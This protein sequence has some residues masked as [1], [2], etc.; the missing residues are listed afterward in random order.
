MT[1]DF[2]SAIPIHARQVWQKRLLYTQQKLKDNLTA[3]NLLEIRNLGSTVDID[4]VTK[5]EGSGGNANIQAKITARGAVPDV[6]DVKISE[7]DYKQYQIALGFYVNERELA[8]APELKAQKVDWCTRNIH[9]LEDYMFFNGDSTINLTGLQTAAEA[10][11]NGKGVASSA[12]GS[13][14]N[15]VGAWDGT[16]TDIDIQRDVVEMMSRIGDE[17][18]NSPMYLV[19]RRANLKGIRTLDDMR[20]SYADELLDLFGANSVNDFLRYSSYCPSG[21]VYLVA[22]DGAAAE[23]TISQDLMVD[24]SYPKEKGANYYVELRE[25][26]N[27]FQRYDD[28]A[29]VEI[30]VT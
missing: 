15:N 16:D 3:R 9:R 12:S 25:W 1:L 6:S 14:F 18:A 13:D 28:Q 19:G 21:Y 4:T 7:S 23:M 27:P 30:V 8:Q 5:V 20:T 26:M 10:N 22:K 2:G 11:I 17:F 29:F 24:T